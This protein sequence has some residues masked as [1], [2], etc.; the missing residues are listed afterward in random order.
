ME[1]GRSEVE[2]LHI[3]YGGMLMTVI[4]WIVL[5]HLVKIGRLI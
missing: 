1:Y 4:L 3:E 2:T 5:Q